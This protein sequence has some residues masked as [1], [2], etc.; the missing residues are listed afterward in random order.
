M[1]RLAIIFVAAPLIVVA[2]AVAGIQFGW[3]SPRVGLMVSLAAA[4]IWAIV[5]IALFL[6]GIVRGL[7]GRP[8]W[9]RQFV[10]GLLPVLLLGGMFFVRSSSMPIVMSNDVSTDLAQ[11]PGF[12]TGPSAQ[13]GMSQSAQDKQLEAYP[14]IR[15][16]VLKQPAAQVFAQTVALGKLRGWETVVEDSDAGTVQWIARSRLFRFQ[17]DVSLRITSVAE[18]TKVDMRSRSRIGKSDLGANATRI[19]E[20]FKELQNRFG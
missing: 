3:L 15:T 2:A 16:L 5:G 18:E 6:I 17:D 19:R 13:R 7:R 1:L 12:T 10:L 20:F 9:G 4:A 14:D 11:P 8:R